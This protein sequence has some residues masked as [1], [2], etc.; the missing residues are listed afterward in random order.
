MITEQLT[1]RC[2]CGCCSVMP[3][4]VECVCCTEI[5][6][7]EVKKEQFQCITQHEGFEAVC[8][9]VWVLQAA[10][11]SYRQRYGTSD[12]RRQ[13][14]HEY[15]PVDINLKMNTVA[16][17]YWSFCSSRQYRFIAYRQLTG[18]CWGWLGR[19]VRVTLPSCAVKAIR[20]KFPSQ[21]YAGFKY[22]SL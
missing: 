14:L 2:K 22:P 16:H 9:N 15:V 5:E 18:W 1:N 4:A 7:I 12:M 6:E 10:F 19:R 8:L 21:H 13:S 3:T 11:Y 17:K 20:N